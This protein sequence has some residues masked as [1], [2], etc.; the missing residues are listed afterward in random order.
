MIFVTGYYGPY[1]LLP[2]FLG[3]NGIQ[4]AVVYQPHPN[5]AFDAFR[6]RVRSRS[7]CEMVPLAQ[8]ARR[9][10]ELLGAG[11]TVAIVADHQAAKGGAP[12]DFLGLPRHAYRSVALL[13]WRY[14]A[15]VVVAGIRRTAEPFQFE[16][17]LADLILP[18]DWKECD[19]AVE[20]I[21]H[22]YLAGLQQIVKADP[23]QYLWA[24]PRANKMTRP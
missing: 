8:A 22:R 9:F 10:G 24:Y 13:A 14:G 6:Q 21:T 2:V 23:S 7:G 4:P 1:D 5:A 20:Y 18:A 15:A 3:Y 16:W 12:A 11:G 19:D 17:V